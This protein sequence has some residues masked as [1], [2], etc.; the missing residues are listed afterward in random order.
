MRARP[1]RSTSAVFAGSALLAAIAALLTPAASVAAPTAAATSTSASARPVEGR[2]VSWPQCPSG[3]GG[4]GLPMPPRNAGFVVIGLTNGRGFT[5]NPCV[6]SQAAWARTHR[7]PAAAYLMAT[8]PT[9]AQT[10]RWGATGPLKGTRH[11]NRV[12]NAGW[13]QA[14]DAVG[15][16]RRSGLR[17][18][19]V[20]IDV[21]GNR[22]RPWSTDTTANTALIRGVAAALRRA[23]L[24]TGLYTNRSSWTTYTG[25]AQLGL[26]EWRT[27]G[28][29]S[30]A[31]AVAACAATPLNGGPVLLAQH[32]TTTVDYNVLCPPLTSRAAFAR[33]FAVR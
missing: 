31:D 25:G 33:W 19:A 9:R 18:T 22:T 21:E 5:A 28:P 4:Y 7:V 24:R 16:L 1:G 14:A 6:R 3:R 2:D 30:R 26:P 12:Y 27:V 10:R 11:L 20:W 23:G 15:V 13:A 17:V 29:R 32:W 8:Y